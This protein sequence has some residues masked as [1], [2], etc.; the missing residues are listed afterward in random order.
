MSNLPLVQLI[1]LKPRRLLLGE[2]DNLKLLRDLFGS[3]QRAVIL[4]GPPGTGKTLVAEELARQLSLEVSGRQ[5]EECRLTSIFPDF[6]SKHYSDDEITNRLKLFTGAPFIWD[7]IVLHSSYQYEDLVRGFRIRPGAEGSN[8]ATAFDVVEGIVGF[9]CRVITIMNALGVSGLLI[10]DE[11][12]RAPIGRIFGE[13]LY[14]MDR[15][16]KNVATAYPVGSK[17]KAST[18][19]SFPP[20][21]VLVGTMNSSDRSA[22]GF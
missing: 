8:A 1:E 2:S 13:L 12:N 3:G 17:D 7:L 16:G 21:L 11:I 14:A 5:A 6:L 18:L 19:L 22:S 10:L 4:E 9:A 20:G 15:R